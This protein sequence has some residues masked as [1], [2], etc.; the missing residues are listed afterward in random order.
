MAAILSDDFRV[1]IAQ[2][3]LDSMASKPSYVFIG[4]D[5]AWANGPLDPKNSSKDTKTVLNNIIQGKRIFDGN[6]SLVINRFD[7]TQNVVYDI[8]DDEDEFLFSS[9]KKFYVLTSANNVYKCLSNNAGGP[10]TVMPT[11]KSLTPISLSD[12]YVWK[13]M[14]TVPGGEAANFLTSQFIPVSDDPAESTDQYL[15]KSVAIPGGVQSYK[16]NSG[17][18][19]YSTAAVV[20]NGD[21]Q[22]A[23]GVAE[24]SNGSIVNILVSDPG[25]NYTKA[26]VTIVGDGVGAS[27]RPI[28]AP[29]GGHGSNAAYELGAH[30]TMIKMDF[31][32]IENDRTVND[33]SYRQ[34]GIVSNVIEP[35]SGLPL[36]DVNLIGTIK[37]GVPT[38]GNI[39]VG[40]T[41]NLMDD[42]STARVIG[43]STS[44]GSFIILSEC[45]NIFTGEFLRLNSDSP[46]QI[47]SV[48]KSDIKIHTGNICYIENRSPITKNATQT[49]TVRIIIEL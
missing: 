3:F 19:G 35:I 2:D 10:S 33:F 24:I 30:Y 15:V 16:I 39:K 1:K 49:E 4:K 6:M 44:A 9:L 25:I 46:I 17:G 14:F 40:D 22:N 32:A 20:V 18:A 23:I 21:G 38:I 48:V 8:Y 42:N 13:Y 7:W 41:I 47:V 28:L 43:T 27:V 5:S 29:R 26:T 12:K 45:R 36:T 37:I 11:G 31:S 34:V